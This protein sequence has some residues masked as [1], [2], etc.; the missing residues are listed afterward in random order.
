MERFGRLGNPEPVIV[1]VADV[2]NDQGGSVAVERARAKGIPA[3]QVDLDTEALP[4]ADGT[5][6]TVVSNSMMEHRFFPERTLDEAV[7]VLRAG[8]RFIA[9]LP[10]MAHWICRWW[11]LTGRFPYV[12]DSPTDAMHLRFFTVHDA[13]ALC[14]SRGIE[15]QEVD[16][17]ASLWVKGFYPALLRRRPFSGAYTWLARH[18]PSLFARDFILVGRKQEKAA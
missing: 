7:R 6:D 4:Y 10:N 3:Q 5:F 18:W 11:V 2:L 17:S 16:G 9:C 8:G 1:S 14:A 12:V 15:V 13:R